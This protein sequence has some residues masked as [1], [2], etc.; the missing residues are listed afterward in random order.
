VLLR[1]YRHRLRRED[2]EDCFSQATLEIVLLA[3]TGRAYSSRSHIAN[4]L[5]QRFQARIQDRRR[6]VGGRSPIQAAME[7]A[8][9]FGTGDGGAEVPDLRSEPERV[10]LAR[11]ELAMLT[12]RAQELTADQKLVLA[13]QVALQ[14]GCRAFCERHGWSP[15]KY[16]KVAQRARARL[17]LLM[18]EES[19]VPLR[20]RGSDGASGTNL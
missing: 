17:R 16:R 15:E 11:H 20:A 14:I 10:L 9:S 6:A 8:L 3:R 13:S 18:A 1:V 5:E 7:S 2:L 12:T 4:S 19:V